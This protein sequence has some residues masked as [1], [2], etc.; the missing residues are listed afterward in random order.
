MSAQ[1]IRMSRVSHPR[2]SLAALVLLVVFFLGFGIVAEACTT[3]EPT[4]TQQ[5]E[6]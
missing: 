1:N 2:S 3:E 6:F 4:L 5:T